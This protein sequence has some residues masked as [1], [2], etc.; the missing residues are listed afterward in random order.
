MPEGGDFVFDMKCVNEYTIV[1]KAKT[2]NDKKRQLQLQKVCFKNKERKER[3]MYT[4][5][6]IE[7]ESRKTCKK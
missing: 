2:K 7:D 5:Y 1:E 4:R 3:T 6:I